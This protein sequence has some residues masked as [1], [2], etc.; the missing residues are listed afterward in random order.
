M[1]A[2]EERGSV[3]P[4][5]HGSNAQGGAALEMTQRWLSELYDLEVSHPVGD[6]VCSAEQARRLVGDQ[7]DRGEVLIVHESADGNSVGLYIE[8]SA[9][10]S[11]ER[12]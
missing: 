12:T 10:A 6:F 7:V 5:D 4:P 9:I 8:A 2:G 1:D 3:M 11:Y